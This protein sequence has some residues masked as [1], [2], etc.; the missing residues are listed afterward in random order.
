MIKFLRVMR[1]DD[2]D[3]HVYPTAAQQGELAV[4]GSLLFS[5]AEEDPETW[6]GKRKQAFRT[7]FLGLDSFGWSTIVEIAEVPEAQFEHAVRMLAHHLVEHY[8]APSL[9][10]AM[11]YAR[12]EA[13]YAAGLCEDP[14]GTLLMVER[15][16]DDEG[17]HEA[18]RR[19]QPPALESTPTRPEKA[20]WRGHDGEIRIWDM[21][22]EDG[23]R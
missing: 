1:L 16:A 7:G 4:T 11:P 15:H 2:S 3:E 9:A 6:S 5:F 17:I 23:G 13:E 20:D 22:P 8:G 18:F 14:P 19:V 21:F 10:E 12:Q